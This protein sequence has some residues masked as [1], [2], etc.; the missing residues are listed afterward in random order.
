LS[1]IRRAAALAA[2]ALLAAPGVA[3]ADGPQIGV[4]SFTEGPAVNGTR[5]VTVPLARSTLLETVSTDGGS[6]FLM[7]TLPGRWGT[8]RVTTYGQLGGISGDGRLLVLGQVGQTSTVHG[9]RLVLFQTQT[10]RWHI[11]HLPGSFSFDAFSQ[12]GRTLYLIQHVGNPYGSVYRVR[13][14][15]T[16]EH[17]LLPKVIAERWAGSTTMS[18]YPI[19]RV[20]GPDGDWVFTLYQRP[21]GGKEFVHALDTAHRFAMCINIPHSITRDLTQLLIRLAADHDSV[22]LVEHGQVVGRIGVDDLRL[23]PVS[24]VQP[25]HAAG[26]TP[27]QTQSD[28]PWAPIAAGFAAAILAAGGCAMILRRRRRHAVS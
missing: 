18:G 2:L 7:D 3:R 19:D 9:T 26:S 6:V 27:P 12:D 22:E 17:R 11:I 13:A 4:S 28:R 1:V 25:R 15:D 20:T 23:T 16:R 8:W 14:Y 5:Y 21:H 10:R 24:R